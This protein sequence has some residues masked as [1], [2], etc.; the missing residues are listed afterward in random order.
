MGGCYCERVPEC[1]RTTA[2]IRLGP[3]DFS[4]MGGCYCERVPECLR[5]T[6]AIRLGHWIFRA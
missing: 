1:L 5:T 3:L 4:H 6:A 2:A